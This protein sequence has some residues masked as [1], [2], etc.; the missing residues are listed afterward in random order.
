MSPAH[1]AKCWQ[2]ALNWFVCRRLWTNKRR[3]SRH[4]L[5]NKVWI[6][7]P[8]WP[9]GATDEMR[10]GQWMGTFIQR[11]PSYRKLSVSRKSWRR[12]RRTSRLA[13]TRWWSILYLEFLINFLFEVPGRGQ[14]RVR[15]GGQGG[16]QG[17]HH[18][19]GHP[20][21]VRVLL[22]LQ[23]LPVDTAGEILDSAVIF[24]IWRN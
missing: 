15:G 5:V 24:S 22:S 21:H 12:M 1:S 9:G 14:G 4:K 16:V 23:R 3:H 10:S 7:P 6:L 18:E 8:A 11:R 20:R 17:V 13:G 2:E 19:V